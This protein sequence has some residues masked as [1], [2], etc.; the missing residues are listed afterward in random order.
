[1]I[2]ILK[3]RILMMEGIVKIISD[4]NYSNEEKYTELNQ[5]DKN[6]FDNT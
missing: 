1:M 6:N 2:R 5:D 3:K 4:S